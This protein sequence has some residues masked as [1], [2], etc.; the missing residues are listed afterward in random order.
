MMKHM[1]SQRFYFFL[2]AILNEYNKIKI[3]GKSNSLEPI[4]IN[5]TESVKR[6]FADDNI[7]EQDSD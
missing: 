6:K 2:Y 3:F 1:N 7:S 5:K 4:K